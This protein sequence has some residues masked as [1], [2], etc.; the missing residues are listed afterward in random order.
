M[1]QVHSLKERKNSLG[2]YSQSRACADTREKKLPSDGSRTQLFVEVK[3][4]CIRINKGLPAS[5]QEATILGAETGFTSHPTFCK[6]RVWDGRG[7]WSSVHKN[8]ERCALSP[9][10]KM[11]PALE[12]GSISVQFSKS[13]LDLGQE[14]EKTI[15]L[16]F[17]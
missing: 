15:I 14:G 2:S 4:P 9:A 11:L 7:Q 6:P 8:V 1:S 5:S 3:L 10:S 16:S 12:S 17:K 13:L